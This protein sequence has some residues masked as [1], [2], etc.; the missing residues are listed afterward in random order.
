MKKI[1]FSQLLNEELKR[2]QDYIELIAS[3]NYVSSDVLIAAGSILTNKYAE[4]FPEKRYYGGCEIIDKIETNAINSAK[5]LFNA[6]YVDVQPHSGSTANSIVYSALLNPYD[7]VLAMGLNEGGHL[8]HGSKV[9]FSG[10]LY[11]FYHYGVNPET[12]YLDYDEI[13]KI[14]LDIKPKLIV[15]GA[16]NYSRMIDFGKF[17]NIAKKVNAYLMADIAHIAGLVAVGEHMNPM[18]YCDVVTSTTHKTLRGPRGGLIMSN[19]SKLFN[20]LKNATFP[21]LQGG[22]LE[23]IIAAKWIAFEEASQPEF[24]EYI[25]QVIKNAKVFANYFK[26]NGFSVIAN[27]TDNHLFSINVFKTTNITGDVIEKWLHSAK[28]VVNKNTIPYDINSPHTPSG[29]RLGTAAMTTRGFIEKD[30]I[31]IANWIIEIINSNGNVNVINKISKAVDQK[32]K[33]FPIYTNIKY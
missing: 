11:N 29:I 19:N 33:D 21:G 12:Q 31:E 9:N 16:S 17:Q 3:E 18:S 4:G 15:C 25:K 10:K 14:A 23:H 20:K 27:G 5:K 13:L 2:Q 6:Q 24:K 26:T 30:F 32:L 22:P 28:L 7:K 1:L 8:T